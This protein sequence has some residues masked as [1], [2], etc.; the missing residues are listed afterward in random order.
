VADTTDDAAT[1][2]ATVT[3]M[4]TAVAT[5]DALVSLP[6][7]G[8]VVRRA[9]RVRLGDVSPGGR[10]RLD[11]VARYL[12][13]VANDDARGA[14]APEDVNP[15]VVRRSV[16]V[17]EQFPV[18][19]EELELRTWCSGTGSR[20]AERRTSI[21]GDLGGHVEA[22]A[23][24]VHIDIDT[25]RPKVLSAD[26]A[27]HYVASAMGRTV[28]AR[29]V[30]PDPPA[31]AIV[32]SW[33]VRF[34]DCDVLAHVNNAAYWNPVEE[35]LAARRELRAPL[36]AELEY[37]TPVELDAVGLGGAVALR[38]AAVD[39]GFAQWWCTGDTVHASA[40]VTA[41]AA[42]GSGS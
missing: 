42:P 15:W 12:Q 32:T 3:S 6:P 29:L 26:F 8:R 21:A 30:H 1:A 34:T 17:V 25:G 41:V 24:W 11:T 13:D 38:T 33:P 9:R 10:L 28:R 37:R 4:R 23:V 14:L 5:D 22:A 7:A 19:G 18:Y 35:Q 36:R 20:W 40:V 2:T 31:D 27:E 39:G 16:V